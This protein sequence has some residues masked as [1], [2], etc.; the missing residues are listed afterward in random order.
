M[1]NSKFPYQVYLNSGS[2]SK[3]INSNNDARNI[4][5]SETPKAIR[6]NQFN[7]YTG[8][9]S[10]APEVSNVN[11]NSQQVRTVFS[12]AKNIYSFGKSKNKI[13]S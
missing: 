1:S 11:L 8:K 12:S 3:K 9:F 13:S 6:N 5:I 2:Y 7:P 4:R 10:I